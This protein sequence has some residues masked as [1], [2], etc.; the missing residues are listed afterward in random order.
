MAMDIAERRNG[1]V[2][3]ADA[4]QVYSCWRVLTA[5]PSPEDEERVQHLLY[6]HVDR[7]ARYSV[8]SWLG[9]IEELVDKHSDRLLIVV[10]GTGLYFSTFE[11]GL[12]PIP[13][14]PDSIQVES[15]AILK[16]DGLETMVTELERIDPETAASLDTRNPKRVQ[17]AWEVLKATGRGLTSWRQEPRRPVLPVSDTARIVLSSESGWLSA[18]IES[19]I[20]NMVRNGALAECN[21]AMAC[22]IPELPSAKA[23]GAANL[24][25]YLKG[26]CSL[27]EATSLATVATRQYAKRQRAWF[28]SRMADWSWIEVN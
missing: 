6:G 11:N 3:N 8:G 13:R 15:E 5:R 10:G 4:L 19:R 7:N 17:R 1:I 16:A 2:V 20:K 22:W 28:R 25:A 21:A 27:D 18:R 14:I 24:I 26:E 12:T 23:H 9:E